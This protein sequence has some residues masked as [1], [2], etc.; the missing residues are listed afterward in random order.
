MTTSVSDLLAPVDMEEPSA[1]GVTPR[2]LRD[3]QVQAADAVEDQ[4]REGYERTSVVLPT[5]SGKPVADHELVPTPDRGFVRMCDLKVGDYVFGSDGEPTRI[6]HVDPQGVIPLR[7]VHFDD[8]AHVVA[9]AGHLWEIKRRRRLPRVETTDWIR[10]QGYQD[11]DGYMWRLPIIDPVNYPERDL[12]LDPYLMG[13]LIANGSMKTGPIITTPDTHVI[14][15]LE[16]RGVVLNKH[17]V[18]EKLSLIHI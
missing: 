16:R 14:D 1:D 12:P 13:T 9:G 11:Y 17:Q 8:G 18:A 2:T 7:R 15:E 10:K 4:W 6:V 3:Y 5:G